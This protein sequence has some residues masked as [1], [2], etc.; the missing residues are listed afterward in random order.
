MAIDFP[1]APTVGDVFT[2]GSQSW[3]W[4]GVAWQL[5]ISTVVGPTGPTGAASDVTGPTGALGPKGNFTVVANT[6]PPEP[7]N[8][9]A[10]FNSAN[11]R[12]FIYYDD[13]TSAAWVESASSNVGPP[14]A[15]GPTG[16]QGSDSQVP[17]P[18]GP[19]GSTGPTGARGQTGPAGA[20]IIGPTGPRGDLGPTG[21]DGVTGPQGERGPTGPQ[22][23]KGDQGEEGIEGPTGPQGPTGADSTVTGPTGP[24]GFVGATGPQ[25]ST[26]PTGASI[27]GP[28]GPTGSTGP[29]GGP[30]GP[31]GPTGSLGPT[32]PQ[33][34]AGIRGATGPT[35]PTGAASSVPG[36]L[37]DPGPTG[38]TGPSGPR[39][40]DYN[41]TFSTTTRT[42]GVGIQLFS[43]GSV[44]AYAL[45][46]R[47]RVS[48]DDGPTIF[49]E[50]V[51]TN[52]SGNDI[53][54]AIDTTAGSGTFNAWVFSL[55]GERG[56]TGPTGPTGAAS[57]VTGPT[58]PLGPVGP[59]GP[60]GPA[61]TALGPTGPTG[62]TGAA[63]TVTGPTGPPFFELTGNTYFASHTLDA[64]DRASLVRINSSS[65]TTLT[66]PPDSQYNFPT[67]TQIVVVQLGVGQTTIAAG[68]GVSLLSEGNR[69]ATKARYATASLIKLSANQ[70]IL[71]GNLSVV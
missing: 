27:T 44:G 36:P 59:T 37:G 32:G 40:N 4:D 19:Q 63:S 52:I 22:G 7:E 39:G 17:G 66:V 25:G 60:T 20:S 48:Y 10:W 54:V 2:S 70:W 43:V 34:D 55:A 6:P 49:M 28:T 5:I 42:I 8:G 67:G 57:T 46:N 62:P 41:V 65:S 58:G 53:T 1:D 15:T 38:P 21:A 45:G 51:I 11:G 3:Q 29:S 16:A 31:T 24:R 23:D 50:G 9:D 56:P 30:T 71:T 68:S 33:G 13:E 47:V 12:I 14:G 64:S 61:S 26:G 35:G 69:F 18:T